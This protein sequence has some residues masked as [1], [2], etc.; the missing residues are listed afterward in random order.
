MSRSNPVASS[1]DLRFAS[2]TDVSAWIVIVGVFSPTS[3]SGSLLNVFFGLV[4]R[5]RSHLAFQDAV[6]S[7]NNLV[8]IIFSC[9]SF[10]ICL[11]KEHIPF[12]CLC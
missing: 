2:R 7:E 12:L 11:P 8:E 9:R 3:V 1:G 5:D 4:V 6:F 10:K